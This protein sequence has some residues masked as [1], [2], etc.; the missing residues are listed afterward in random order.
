MKIL[1]AED[2]A[3]TR[4]RL[5]GVLAAEGH[6]VVTAADG[7]AAWDVFQAE[8]PSI[9]ISDWMMP[10]LDGPELV[11]R[12]RALANGGATYVLLLTS[13]RARV[14]ARVRASCASSE[15]SPHVTPS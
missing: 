1:V 14:C 11:R 7:G 8:Q 6:E 15:I 13:K 3:V 10:V 12:I 5:E 2:D 4:A 9:V